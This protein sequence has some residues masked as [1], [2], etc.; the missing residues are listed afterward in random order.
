MTDFGGKT[1][2]TIK[3]NLQNESHNKTEM[4]LELDRENTKLLTN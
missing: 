3:T 4:N 1:I 2:I